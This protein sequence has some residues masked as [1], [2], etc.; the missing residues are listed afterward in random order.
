MI[1]FRPRVFLYDNPCPMFVAFREPEIQ[2]ASDWLSSNP[3]PPTYSAWN[4]HGPERF[5]WFLDMLYL[6]VLDI[7]STLFHV[8]SLLLTEDMSRWK[9]PVPCGTNNCWVSNCTYAKK[10]TK[11]SVK[12]EQNGSHRRTKTERKL[13]LAP[14]VHF[15]VDRVTPFEAL[16]VELPLRAEL[17][18]TVHPM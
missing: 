5:S 8:D 3:A 10:K 1:C 18:Q 14:T 4:C 17:I 6:Q 12:T 16:C 15:S 11:D 2:S 9:L 7:R 13:L